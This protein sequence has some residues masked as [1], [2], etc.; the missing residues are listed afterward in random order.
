MSNQGFVSAYKPSSRIP[1]TKQWL[2][3]VY[4]LYARTHTYYQGGVNLAFES[5]HRKV[6]IMVTMEITHTDSYA[7][8][9]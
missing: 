3:E 9:T 1:E 7:F 2:P 6:M 8:C 4:M 5:L